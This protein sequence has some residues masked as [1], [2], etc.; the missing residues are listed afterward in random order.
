M[1]KSF[2]LS[3]A[4]ALVSCFSATAATNDAGSSKSKEALDRLM[5]GNERYVKD[6]LE[7]PNRTTE[8]RE[9]VST[10]HAPFATVISCSDSR[11][12][13]VLVFDQ[14]IG[15]IFE[16][17]VA[18]NVAGPIEVS[19]IEFASTALGS[20]LIFVLG[21]ENCAAINAVL[22]HQTQDIQPIAER[23]EAAFKQNLKGPNSSLEEGVKA[24]IRGVVQQLRANP[25][26]A[27]LIADKKVEVV[28]GYYHLQSGKVELCC[29]L[30]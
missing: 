27:R 11:V 15:D 6:M 4:L 18:G 29:D 23:V 7:H 20:T 13:P 10:N 30:P 12:A 1:S 9:A 2:C 3:L 24:N 28:G 8:R 17:R 22:T 21:H 26:V 25:V 19:S 14:G 16:V 5:A